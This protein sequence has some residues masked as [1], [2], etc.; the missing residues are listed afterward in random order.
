M[1]G[2]IGLDLSLLGNLLGSRFGERF[3]AFREGA[4]GGTRL[5]S[6]VRATVFADVDYRGFRGRFGLRTDHGIQESRRG[7]R[8]KRPEG[9][10]Q[11]Q[12]AD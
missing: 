6:G 11:R 7:C 8:K 2:G 5:A 1:S 9:P 12:F 4:G 10:E 3:L